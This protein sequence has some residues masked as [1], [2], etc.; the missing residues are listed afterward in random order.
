M[1]TLLRL[2]AAYLRGGGVKPRRGAPGRF[3]AVTAVGRY[4]RRASTHSFSASSILVC[5]PLPVDWKYST[6]SGL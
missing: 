6:T 1:I 3:R 4:D 2:V 5:Q